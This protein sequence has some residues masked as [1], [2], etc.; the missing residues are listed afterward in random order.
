VLVALLVGLAAPGELLADWPRPA[1]G[2]SQSGDPEVVFTFDDGPHEKWSATILDTLEAYRVSAI[3]Y[4]VGHRIDNHRRDS[5]KRRARRALIRRAVSAGHL[6]GNH[7]VNH[8]HLC[9][10]DTDAAAEIDTNHRLYQKLA[11]LPIVLFRAPYGDKCDRL[12]SLLG[13]RGL[14]HSHWDIDPREYKG[15]TADDSAAYVIEKLGKLRGR[16]VVLMHDT[17]GASARALPRIL[18]WIEDENERRQKAG[19]RRI[20]ILSGSDLVVER[21]RG[22][23]WLWGEDV[24]EQASGWLGQ[25]LGSLVP[26]APASEPVAT[27]DGSEPGL[28]RAGA[29]GTHTATLASP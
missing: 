7:T 24:A 26:G 23:L 28:P 27:D 11:E 18:Q 2:R 29:S 8:V 1:A 19:K 21:E 16:A 25:A 13:E 17:K 3:F 20:R 10:A 15:L 9:H 5:K 22:P 12:V 6:I 4:W 14:T